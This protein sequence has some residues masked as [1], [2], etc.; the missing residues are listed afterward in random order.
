MSGTFDSL[1]DV[2]EAMIDWPKRLG[3]ET[4]FYR[5]LF[6]R[7]GARR[8]LDA[9]CGTGHHAALFHGWGLEVEAADLSP[10]MIDRAKAACGEPAGLRWVVR[11][12]QEPVD[13]PGRFDAA[14][15]VGNSLA[16]AGGVP[17]A[18]Q[19]VARLLEAVRPGGL[20]VVHVLNVGSLPDGPCVWQKCRAVELAQGPGLILKGVHRHGHQAY[21]DLL[22]AGLPEGKL[23]HH[24]SVTFIG[25]GAGQLHEMARS[26]GAAEVV[27]YGGYRNQPYE[28]AQ[29]ADLVMVASRGGEQG[30]ATDCG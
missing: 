15:C 13:T 5:A 2:Y 3:H 16:L 22:V 12:F 20:V 28:P 1:A 27:F 18:A 10:A 17:E 6:D 14:V 7:I 11:G 23:L 30:L 4:P 19:A 25:L 24:E 21:V 8:V 9:A 29:S 26:A